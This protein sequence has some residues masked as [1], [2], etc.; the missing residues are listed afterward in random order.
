MILLAVT[1]LVA[2]LVGGAIVL[3]LT[4]TPL[5]AVAGLASVLGAAAVAVVGQGRVYAPATVEQIKK[6]LIAATAKDGA[7]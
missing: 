5:A 3:K 7:P 1:I 6:D 2:V 4:D